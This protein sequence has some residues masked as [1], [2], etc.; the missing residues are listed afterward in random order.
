MVGLVHEPGFFGIIKPIPAVGRS[1]K[2]QVRSEPKG[3]GGDGMGCQLSGT[4]DPVLTPEAVQAEPRRREQSRKLCCVP[5][6]CF[7]LP[8]DAS[9]CN[10]FPEF[11]RDVGIV[12]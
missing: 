7:C 11:Q 10:L 4:L 1:R 12:Q 2:S 5:T 9:K 3:P 6:K 8:A